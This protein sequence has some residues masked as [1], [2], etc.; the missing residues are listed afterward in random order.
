MAFDKKKKPKILWFKRSNVHI[1][2]ESLVASYNQSISVCVCDIRSSHFFYQWKY[3]ATRARKG[4]FCAKHCLS[5]R[6]ER[7]CYCSMCEDL[8]TV[9]NSRKY[10]LHSIFYFCLNLIG[11]T[12][13]CE[14]FIQNC[15]VILLRSLYSPPNSATNDLLPVRRI[16][17][18]RFHVKAIPCIANV[19]KVS[20]IVTV[21]QTTGNVYSYHIPDTSFLTVKSNTSL[22]VRRIR[23]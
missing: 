17:M 12:V 23:L 16:N 7:K 20:H 22:Y 21:S 4:L 18:R 15:T 9:K 5:Y 10:L 6:A 11:C 3:S 14:L 19:S 8:L 13:H 1:I 2:L